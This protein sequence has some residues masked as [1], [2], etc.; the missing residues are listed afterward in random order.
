MGLSGGVEDLSFHLWDGL[1][2]MV[3]FLGYIVGISFLPDIR[4]V[5]EYHGPGDVGGPLQVVVGAG[6][7]LAEDEAFGGP[8]AEEHID[9][10]QKFGLG[11]QVAILGGEL[12]GPAQGADAARHDGDLVH[13]VGTRGEGGHE[14]VSRLVE[15][16]DFFLF[17]IDDAVFLFQAAHG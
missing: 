10:G 2:K 4:R 7:G 11:H 1:F 15:G 9:F 6:G 12:L 8:A 5:F 14:G 16:H 17:G 13:G 3:L